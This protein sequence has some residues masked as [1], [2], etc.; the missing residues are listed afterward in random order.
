MTSYDRAEDVPPSV[1]AV[2]DAQGGIWWRIGEKTDFAPSK[3]GEIRSLTQI[4]ELYGPVEDVTEQER[5]KG[6]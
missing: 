5:Y 1:Y 2:R 3:G 6:V 4:I